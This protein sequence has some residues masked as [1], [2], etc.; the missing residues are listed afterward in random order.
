[1]LETDAPAPIPLAYGTPVRERAAAHFHGEAADLCCA[2][3]EQLDALLAGAA[4]ER[5]VGVGDSTIEGLGDPVDG[6]QTHSFVERLVAALRRQTP[7]LHHLNLGQR[8][9]TAGEV[10]AGQLERAL[11]FA[12]DLAIVICGGN[13]MFP[14]RWDLDAAEQAID[15][16][17]GALRDTGCEVLMNTYMNPVNAVPAFR[18]TPLDERLPQLND[19][20]RRI[21]ARRGGL[22][23]D[24]QDSPAT[25]VAHNFSRD[26]RHLSMRGH[27][28]VACDF[29]RRLHVRLRDGA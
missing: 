24:L 25:H 16:I 10:R 15:A 28:I 4:W 22:L 27:A 11:A 19:A 8:D 23:V 3:P 26:F 5:I 21:A 6:Y 12:P 14:P 17:V 2:T 7:N 29:A 13:D 9:R 1:M 20:V 18:G